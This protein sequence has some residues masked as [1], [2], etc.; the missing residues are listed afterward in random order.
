MARTTIS[1]KSWF[2]RNV[3]QFEKSR[4]GMMTILITLQSC[5]GSIAAMSSL[6]HSSFILL[7]ICAFIT[8][9]SNAAFIAQTTS[10][11]CLRFFYAST[12]INTAIVLINLTMK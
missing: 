8:M 9:A 4:F 7:G 6:M 10:A 12:I 3:E 11:W 2:Q 1:R 5:I